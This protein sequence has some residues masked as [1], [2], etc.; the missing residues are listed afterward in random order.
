MEDTDRRLT[1]IDAKIK[2]ELGDDHTKGQVWRVLEAHTERLNHLDGVIW[3][4]GDSLSAQILKM[5]TEI[6]MVGLAL[7]VLIPAGMK[8]LEWVAK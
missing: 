7:A 4:G 3:Q 8:L 5:R 2:A 1:E 6:R